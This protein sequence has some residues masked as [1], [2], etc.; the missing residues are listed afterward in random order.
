MNRFSQSC[1]K[2]FDQLSAIDVLS[3]D[4]SRATRLNRR[5]QRLLNYLRARRRR[6][7]LDSLT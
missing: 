1:E 3:V 2:L 6:A 5:G 4:R 7:Y